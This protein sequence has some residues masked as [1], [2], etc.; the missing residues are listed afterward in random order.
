[1]KNFLPI[2]AFAALGLC[3]GNTQARPVSTANNCETVLT[4][5]HPR[6][7]NRL[8]KIAADEWNMTVGAA[9][10]AYNAGA[11]TLMEY[12]AGGNNTYMILF[13]GFCILAALE[14]K[15]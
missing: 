12:P 5:I 8:L 10:Q 3:A 7:V 2:L 4:T 9:R 15:F 14:D 6:N 11:I 1:M 13:D